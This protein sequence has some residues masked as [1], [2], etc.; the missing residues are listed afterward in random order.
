VGNL[1]SLW[2]RV[3]TIDTVIVVF[4][5]TS[6]PLTINTSVQRDILSELWLVSLIRVKSILIYFSTLATIRIVLVAAQF[7]Q[8]VIGQNHFLL[9]QAFLLFQVCSKDMQKGKIIWLFK[10]F[11]G[12][13]YDDEQKNWHSL[14]IIITE[15]TKSVFV[16]VLGISWGK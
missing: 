11:R 8:N 4:W 5:N 12:G 7:C 10:Y 2:K 13:N 9:V 14:E 16:V 1:A 6:I 3:S 15:L